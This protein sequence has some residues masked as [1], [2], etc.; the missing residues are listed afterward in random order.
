MGDLMSGHAG[1]DGVVR[2][3]VALQH[4]R[5]ALLQREVGTTILERKA[6]PCK[7]VFVRHHVTDAEIF[8]SCTLWYE[9]GAEAH[10]VG[11]DKAAGVAL[12]VHHREVDRA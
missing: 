9:T 1:D 8:P 12:L 3:L 11:V 10:V 7:V 6:T 5:R 4:I 2:P